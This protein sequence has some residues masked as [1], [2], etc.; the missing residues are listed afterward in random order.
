LLLI[1]CLSASLAWLWTA[2]RPNRPPEPPTDNSPEARYRISPELAGQLAQIEAQQRAFAD[3]VWAQE[4]L[5]QDSGRTF[6]AL[7]D[8]LNA[9]TNKLLLAARFP[10]GE[11]IL[12]EW[13][14]PQRYPHGIEVREPAGS[15]RRLTTPDWRPFAESF[16]GAGWQ[17]LQVEF[18]HNRFET[19]DVGQPGR[20]QFY[21][22]AHLNHLSL[23]QAAV[24]EGTLLIDWAS[25]RSAEG[26]MDIA[27][28]DASHL[29]LK[30]RPGL[31][32]FA[33]ILEDR[34]SPPENAYSID[35][36]VV[37]DL[38]GDGLSEIILAGKNLVYRRSGDGT[39]QGQPLCRHP[40]GLITTAV[41]ADFDGDGAAD[42]LCLKVEGMVLVRGST[43]GTF[44]E[45]GRLVW[46]APSDLKYPMVMSCGDVDRDGDLDVFVGQ[47]KVP[48]ELGSM[49]TPYY[50]AND[51]DPAYLL[52]N[53]GQGRF[54]D[55]T[56]AAG[57][58]AKRSRRTYSGSLADIDADG[59]LDL[60][61]VSDFA[62]LDLYQNNGHGRFS[63]MSDRWVTER[64]AFGMAHVFADFNTDGRLD[65]LMMGMPSPTVERLEHLGLWHPQAT[66]DRASRRRMACG[67]RLYLAHPSGGFG[68]GPLSHTITNSGWSWGASAFDFENDGYPDV[69]VANGLESRQSVTDYE[70]EFWLHDS[71]VGRSQE[72]SAVYLYFKSKFS[73]TRGRGH[74]Y[75]GYEKNRLYLNQGGASFLEAAHLLGVALEQ[76][77]RNVVTDDLDGDGRMDLVLTCFEEWPQS[78]QIVRAYRNAVPAS[79]NWIGFRLREQGQGRSPVGASVLLKYGG[80]QAVRQIVTGD[81]HRSQHPTT[82]HFGLG[83]AQRVD[84]AVIRWP[85]GHTLSLNVP[86]LNRYHTIQR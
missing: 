52:I 53:Q 41:V 62:G 81:S 60:V 85:D 15:G 12:A 23:A 76:D 8:S 73:R 19:N 2:C 51:G 24:L 46:P 67:N 9:S 6:E 59:V 83:A 5:A 37:Y 17:L 27:R 80:H 69:Y 39:Y 66:E 43:A 26:L 71:L 63:D 82:V 45:P 68:P 16:A 84:E 72:D 30:T 18:R 47:Y 10:V 25:S 50:D 65:L 57:L 36:L 56:V 29:T 33:T 61:V 49:P 1:A 54:Q 86:A 20:S 11:L 3:T 22:S 38:D 44:L 14:S 13:K 77:S 58:I 7:W 48:Y 74:S 40:P 35:P 42:L 4:L 75:G 31:S 70:P 78:R 28:I 32:P 21:F 55:G 34:V 79:G 64:R